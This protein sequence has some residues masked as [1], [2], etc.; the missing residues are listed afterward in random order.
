MRKFGF[1]PVEANTINSSVYLISAFLSPIFGTVI[2]LTGRNVM[3]I[4]ISIAGTIGAH[5]LLAFTFITPYVGMVNFILKH[6][7]HNYFLSL[8]IRLKI[9]NFVCTLF[10][11]VDINGICIFNVGK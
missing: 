11:Y 7:Y 6:K 3:W 1:S 8:M 2:D 5:S 9:L 4:F 10:M